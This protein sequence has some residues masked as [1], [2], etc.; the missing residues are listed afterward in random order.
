MGRQFFLG[1]VQRE[2]ARA[3][4]ALQALSYSVES[5][6]HGT[7]LADWDGNL[8]CPCP[9]VRTLAAQARGFPKRWPH[10]PVVVR[11]P[12]RTVLIRV[13]DDGFSRARR[14]LAQLTACDGP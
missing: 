4:R 11:L 7:P 2:P 6:S 8:A 5:R 14:P 12:R 10:R 13:A 1:R 9:H 3:A